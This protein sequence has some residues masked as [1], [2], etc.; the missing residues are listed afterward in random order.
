MY[1]FSD[2]SIFIIYTDV[3]C[4]IDCFLEGEA[5]CEERGVGTKEEV[6]RKVGGGEGRRR[7]GVRTL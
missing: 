4:L 7:G 5:G 3:M 1:I 2:C 6:P